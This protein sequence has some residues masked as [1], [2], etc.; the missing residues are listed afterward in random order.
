LNRGLGLWLIAATWLLASCAPASLPS[1]DGDRPASAPAGPKTL[2]IALQGEPRSLMTLL[3]GDVG[4]T[5]AGRIEDALHQHLM[6][7]DDRGE[8]RPMLVTELP[9]QAKGTWVLRSDGTMQTTYR[10]RDNVLWHDGTPFTAGDVVLAWTVANDSDLPVDARNF[11]SQISSIDTP[12]ERT[13]VLNWSRVNPLADSIVDWDLGPLPS[14]LLGGLYG[15]DKEAFQRS[16]WWNRDFIGLGPYRLAEW[17]LGSHLVARAFND[18][19]AVPRI[20]TVIFKFIPSEPT[21]VANMLAGTVDGQFRALSFNEVMFV[22]DEW[23]RAGK[24]PVAIGQPTTWRV[25]EI[26]YRDEF[27][28][29]GLKDLTNP[30]FRQALVH[31]MDRR[32]LVD[33]IYHGQAPVA[34]TFISQDDIKWDWVKDLVVKYDYD[35]RRA[36]QLLGEL[37]WTRSADGMFAN[38]SGKRVALPYWTT[39]GGQWLE[40]MSIIA[41]DWKNLGLAVDQYVIPTAQSRDRRTRSAFPGVSS[42]SSAPI[43]FTIARDFTSGECATEGNRWTGRNRG[44]YQNPAVD[45]LTD[46]LLSSVD[47]TEHRRIGRELVRM[48]GEEVA[49]LPLYFTVQMIFFREGVTGVLGGSRPSG[50]DTWNIAEWD[51][52]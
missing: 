19:Y 31:A 35:P 50:G 3:G 9:S 15:S 25:V 49:G 38:P 29:P 21:V 5:P 51:L 37:G 18:F 43:L 2:T 26:Q 46:E 32:A 10:L 45:R 30:R 20:D 23:E 24:R 41:D 28:S 8:V 22:K 11:A 7:Y 34:D 47:P 44:C 36:Q 52:K 39:E 17:E 14:H 40:E 42:T 27:R 48:H 33:H 13:I 1:A 4:G 12:D 6:V 16:T